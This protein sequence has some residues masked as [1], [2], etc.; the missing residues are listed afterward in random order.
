M[1]APGGSSSEQEVSSLGQQMSLAEGSWDWGSGPCM[2]RS[3][4]GGE[5]QSSGRAPVQ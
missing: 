4:V 2:V 3:R 5:V 1:S